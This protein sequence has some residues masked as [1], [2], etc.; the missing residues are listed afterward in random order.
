MVPTL[1]MTTSI[2]MLSTALRTERSVMTTKHTL[3]R[4]AG[5]N[6]PL[7]PLNP[8]N[9]LSSTM[10]PLPQANTWRLLWELANN[11]VARAIVK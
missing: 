8:S 1:T 5:H 9:A 2:K 10:A 3:P 7:A 11:A 4:D 6:K